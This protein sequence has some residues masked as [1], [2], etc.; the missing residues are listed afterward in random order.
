MKSKEA[1]SG[2][3]WTEKNRIYLERLGIIDGRTGRVRKT[4]HGLNNFV[5]EAITIVCEEGMHFLARQNR[6][7][8]PEELRNAYVKHCVRVLGRRI[9]KDQ[10]KI[11]E[12]ANTRVTARRA[13]EL[14]EEAEARIVEYSEE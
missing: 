6:N 13:R 10:Q 2:I 4:G 1:R 12:L 9:E 11:V 7:A 3:V 8:S 14:V 5:N